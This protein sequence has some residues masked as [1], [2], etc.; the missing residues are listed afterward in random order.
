MKPIKVLHI[1]NS[2]E[3]GGLEK[4]IY[5]FLEKTDF[6]EISP[7]IG[8][9]NGKGRLRSD[10]ESLGLP[11]Y[12]FNLQPGLDLRVSLKIL[13]IINRLKIDIV[14]THNLGPHFYGSLASILGC[15]ALKVHT[16][17]GVTGIERHGSYRKNRY[18]DRSKDYIVA[19]SKDVESFLENYW[20]PRCN[21]VTI[22]NG[23]SMSSSKYSD[24]EK[25]Q[26]RQLIGARPGDK[27][28][29]H[30]GRLS[31]VKDQKTLL[32]AFKLLCNR[33]DNCHLVIIGDGPLSL[34]LRQLSEEL[35]IKSQVTFLG[36]RNDVDL[37]LKLFDLFVL[38]S[39]SEGISVALLEAMASK[40]T[41]L[42]TAVGGNVE[43]IEDNVNGLLTSPGNADEMASKMEYLL[44]N[45]ERN[46]AMSMNAEKTILDKFSMD[47][48]VAQYC[49]IYRIPFA[50]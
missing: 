19:V 41:P 17:H 40:V 37:F 42:V 38:S 12:D 16:E 47:R 27:I 29:G 11:I 28:I 23:I 24:A 3:I 31:A 2:F 21:L 4:L 33:M 6:N 36:A 44:M 18:L 14:H 9:L 43:V 32:K 7:V 50:T 8:V 10:F 30:V 49:Q 15:V 25:S 1:L 20:N 39:I 48:M 34:D 35:N 26:A 13:K 46:K 45:D 22:N 5:Y